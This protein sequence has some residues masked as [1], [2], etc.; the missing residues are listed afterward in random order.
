M[1]FL[2]KL[3]KTAIE[4]FTFLHEAYAKEVTLT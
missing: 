1:R 3:K 2:V 4:T